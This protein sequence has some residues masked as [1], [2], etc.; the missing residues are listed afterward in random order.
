MLRDVRLPPAEGGFEM[1]NTSLAFANRK[2]DGNA[3][4]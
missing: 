4:R 1:A 2:Q 3:L